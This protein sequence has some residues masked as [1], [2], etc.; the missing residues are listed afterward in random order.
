MRAPSAPAPPTLLPIFWCHSNSKT[1]CVAH[2]RVCRKPT[3]GA[4][5]SNSQN[6]RQAAFDRRT[7]VRPVVCETSLVNAS[8]EC[9]GHATALRDS[10]SFIVRC[11][12]IAS[13]IPY[14]P[15]N[16]LVIEYEPRYTEKVRSAL[17]GRPFDITFVHDGEEAVRAFDARRP[18]LIVLSSMVPKSNTA[19]LI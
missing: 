10:F 4:E 7:E 2:L 5:S 19:E 15:E 16:I 17:A 13:F 1:L 8:L 9:G 14:M 12:T 3:I 11:A 18:S 6:A